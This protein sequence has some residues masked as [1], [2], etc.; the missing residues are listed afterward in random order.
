MLVGLCTGSS[1]SMSTRPLSGSRRTTLPAPL[2][3]SH[4]NPSASTLRHGTTTPSRFRLLWSPCA[5]V[6]VPERHRGCLEGRSAV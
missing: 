6:T 2:K 3:A 4:R 1:T 5:P